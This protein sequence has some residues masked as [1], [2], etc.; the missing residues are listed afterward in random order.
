MAWS[1]SICRSNDYYILNLRKTSLLRSFKKNVLRNISMLYLITILRNWFS[2]LPVCLFPIYAY[3]WLVS[4][5][6]F[7]SLAVSFQW[8]PMKEAEWLGRRKSK[9]TRE[10]KTNLIDLN[11]LFQETNICQIIFNCFPLFFRIFNEVYCLTLAVGHNQYTCTTPS[12][13]E[14][15]R[16]CSNIRMC[17]RYTIHFT[18][19]TVKPCHD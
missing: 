15:A 10:T 6:Y 18:P 17:M 5:L 2:N 13:V 3:E 9:C 12:M 16:L 1:L 8:R 7:C 14:S 4:I 19:F 11:A